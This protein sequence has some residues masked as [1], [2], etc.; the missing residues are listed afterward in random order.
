MPHHTSCQQQINGN[1]I[2]GFM[3]GQGIML[4]KESGTYYTPERTVEFMCDYIAEH[5]EKSGTILEPSAGD[6]RFISA[7]Q[8]RNC[9]KFYTAVEYDADKI[10]ELNAKIS[11]PLTRVIAKD[12]LQAI[13]SWERKY[14]LV[15]GNPPYI[16]IKNMEESFLQ[17]GRL[18]CKDYGLPEN[19]IKN[20]W[21]AFILGAMKVLTS[22]G[23]IF[24]VLPMEFLQVKYAEKLRGF[25]EEHF[26]TIHIITFKEKMFPEIEQNTCLVYLTNEEREVPYICYRQYETLSSKDVLYQSQ[27]KK[28][29]PLKKWTNAVLSDSDIDLLKTLEGHFEPI[30]NFASSR[31]GIVTGAN[32]IFILNQ[33]EVERFQC[34]K[35]VKPI[36]S[37]AAMVRNSINIDQDLID[38]LADAGEKIFFL[39]LNGIN[40]DDMSRELIRYLQE[41]GEIKRNNIEIRKSYKCSRRD[42]WYAVPVTKSGTAVFFKRYDTIPRIC[43]KPEEIFTT[44][45]AYNLFFK[46]EIDSESFAFSFYN[47]LT[48]AL[49]EYSGRYYAGGVSE[50]IPEEFKQLSIPYSLIGKDD[51]EKLKCMFRKNSSIE[52]ILDFVDNFTL[53]NTISP[54]NI[55]Q[56][57][58][59]RENLIKR[60]KSH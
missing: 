17:E 6:G 18:L 37:K 21:V 44:D 53:S 40:E 10:K 2:D 11:S 1:V 25:L 50:L 36:I 49:C 51:I 28:N 23:C 39:D 13:K 60:R 42:P 20:S 58:L 3:E 34:D 14:D 24:F 45:I 22:S 9:G 27:I 8:K 59:I 57:R 52:D 43:I 56:L 41:S 33:A 26:D 35:F 48:L 7:L 12:F 19:L 47:S 5:K 38:G 29:K 46:E 54:K 31:P 16:N 55:M 32:K 30:S 4:Q 15:I